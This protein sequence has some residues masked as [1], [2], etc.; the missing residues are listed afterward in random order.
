MET[1]D[2]AP[3]PARAPATSRTPTRDGLELV[4]EHHRLADPRARLVI[5]HGFGEHRGRYQRLVGELLA[6]GFECH[7]FDLRGHGDSGGRRGHVRRF[8]D[9]RDDLARFAAR[10]GRE[11]EPRSTAPWV[12]LGHSL[13]G[14][15]A[16]DSVLHAPRTFSA[17]A[18][19]SPFLASPDSPP[20]AR[21]MAAVARRLLPGL[22]L[23]VPFPPSALSHDPRVVEAYARDPRVLDSFSPAWLGAVTAAQ[24]RVYRRAG[25][26]RLPALV[27][28]G[29]ADRIADPGR[30]LAF[31]RRLGSPDKTLH[32]Y[33][34]LFHEVL[35]ELDRRPVVADLLAWLGRRAEAE[36]PLPPAR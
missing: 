31:F 22:R 6:A 33:D 7:L 11:S 32:V 17:L 10:A 1:P 36:P 28:V 2:S 12:L 20:L 4:G 29:G 14:L 9:Y 24:R 23:H 21:L 15:I 19:G 16:A 35:N 27:L 26:I 5:V 25:E 13:G 30:S 3:P 34:G 8:A 18:L